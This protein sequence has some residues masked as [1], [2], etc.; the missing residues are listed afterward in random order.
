MRKRSGQMLSLQG[1]ITHI[2]AMTLFPTV[3]RHAHL[4]LLAEAQSCPAIQSPELQGT[5]APFAAIE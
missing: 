4:A 1:M 3:R 5:W 2:D